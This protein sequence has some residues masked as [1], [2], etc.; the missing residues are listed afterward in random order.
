MA[1]S[2]RGPFTGAPAKATSPRVGADQSGGDPQRRRLAAARRP[3]DAD[4]LASADLEAQLAKHEVIAEG[5]VDVAE[6]DQRRLEPFTRRGSAAFRIDVR[7]RRGD[8]ARPGPRRRSVARAIADS[9][10]VSWL[11]T[12]SSRLDEGGHHQAAVAIGLVVEARAGGQQPRRAAGRD[13]RGV[14]ALV[15]GVEGRL[16]LAEARADCRRCSV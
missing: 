16:S 7:E 3:D 2:R 15:Q 14:E 13:Q 6:R 10:S 4:D 12:K 8:M 1:T 9:A 11:R 5:E